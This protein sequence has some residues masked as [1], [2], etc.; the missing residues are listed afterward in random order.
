MKTGAAPGW[1]WLT[2]T[3]RCEVKEMWT[4]NYRRESRAAEP[5]ADL[6]RVTLGGNPAGVYTGG[7]RRWLPVYSPGGYRWRPSAGDKVLVVKTGACREAPC[8]AGM[9]QPGGEL[10][11]GEVRLNGGRGEVRLCADGVVLNGPVWINGQ[12]L[13]E[14]ILALT[15]GGEGGG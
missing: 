5:A 2:R 8:I 6:G 13:E 10:E 1:S 11:P 4:S 14:Y 15:A 3:D 12:R 7:E 9:E